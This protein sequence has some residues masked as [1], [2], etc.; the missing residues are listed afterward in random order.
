M[1]EHCAHSSAFTLG[2]ISVATNKPIN[3]L[4]SFAGTQ[5][6]ARLRHYCTSVCAPYLK[7]S[8][9]NVNQAYLEV[10]NLSFCLQ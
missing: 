8:Y 6:R 3:A 9:Q 1:S 2:C 5:T 4:T 10:L 7:V